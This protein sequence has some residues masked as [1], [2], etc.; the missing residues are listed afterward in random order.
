MKT[1]FQMMN[2]LRDW[3]PKNFSVMSGD[4]V[5]LVSKVL[6]LENRSILELRNLRDFTVLILD[7][8]NA[9]NVSDENWDEHIKHLDRMSAITGVIDNQL[10]HMGAEI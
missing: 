2:E 9:K 1:N 10:W 8:W 5:E 6:E 4:E 3:F 7:K